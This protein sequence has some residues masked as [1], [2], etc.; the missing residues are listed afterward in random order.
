M[1][2]LPNP[3]AQSWPDS[4]KRSAERVQWLC[5]IPTLQE[6]DALE[7]LEMR[8]VEEQAK[9]LHARL[10]PHEGDS[11]AKAQAMGALMVA[12]PAQPIDDGV[13]AIR[14]G[15]FLKAVERFPAWAVAQAC[16]YWNAGEHMERGENRAFP[17]SPPQLVR[18]C[19]V[20]V[21]DTK[22][23]LSK[24]QALLTARVERKVDPEMRERVG[25]QIVELRDR[26]AGNALAQD[27]EGDET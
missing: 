23:A 4:V 5:G 18:L 10:R 6:E 7:P 11:E 3:I 22:S 2:S 12:F 24:L 16:D 26:L 20:A 17:P 9:E 25:A 21:F 27:S 19:E 13:A 1:A 15:Q 14:A 8:W